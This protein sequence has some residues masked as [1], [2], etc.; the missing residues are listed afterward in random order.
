[1][2]DDTDSPATDSPAGRSASSTNPA[3]DSVVIERDFAAPIERVWRMWTD[4]EHFASWYGPAGATV[5]VATMDVRVGG[6]RRVCMEMATPGG[7]RRMWFGGEFREIDPPRRLVYTE[8]MTDED[9][10]P[11]PASAIGM[12]DGH[13]TT[14]EVIVELH[15]HGDRTRLV[16]THAGI[17]AGSPGETGWSMA[18]DSLARHLG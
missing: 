5:P 17:P 3:A 18:L 10:T 9:G 12:P 7:T 13:P 1:M 6:V 4:P 14:T 2:A 15:Q 16:L 8:A 11:L